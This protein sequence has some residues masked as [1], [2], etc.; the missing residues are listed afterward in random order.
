MSSLSLVKDSW[1]KKV[2][3]YKPDQS[4]DL[5]KLNKVKL[6]ENGSSDSSVR[7]V[8]LRLKRSRKAALSASAFYFEKKGPRLE[9]RPK[10]KRPVKH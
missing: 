6:S 10:A 9:A 5:I 4:H 2:K 8:C 7:A 1:I 3:R